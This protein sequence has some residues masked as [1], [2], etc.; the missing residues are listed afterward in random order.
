M[1]N[2]FEKFQKEHPNL[3]GMT[4]NVTLTGN[5]MPNRKHMTPEISSRITVEITAS[6]TSDNYQCKNLG[7]I[8][9]MKIPTD[10]KV[11]DNLPTGERLYDIHDDILGYDKKAEDMLAVSKALEYDTCNNADTV[12][13]L[14][15]S[16]LYYVEELNV[17][18][19]YRHYTSS[20]A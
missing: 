1:K 8:I 3:I 16:D 5:Y 6:D 10:K 14:T 19:Q 17:S 2:F 11:I 9:L 4:F 7:K 15:F 20:A 13:A 12:D 18:K